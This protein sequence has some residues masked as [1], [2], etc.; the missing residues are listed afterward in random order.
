M[1]LIK[2][3]LFSCK[4]AR[5]KMVYDKLSAVIETPATAAS[6]KILNCT[7]SFSDKYPSSGNSIDETFENAVVALNSLQPNSAVIQESILRRNESEYRH[8]SETQTYL[9]RIGIDVNDLHDFPAIHVA[10][11]KGKVSCL[12]CAH[13]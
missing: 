1:F 4:K 12:S 10:G 2:T 13:I 3:R 5:L 11:T 8:I 9:K 6:S 7:R